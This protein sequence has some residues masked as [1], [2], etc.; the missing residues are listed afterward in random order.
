MTKKTIEEVESNGMTYEPTCEHGVHFGGCNCVVCHPEKL[1]SMAWLFSP[2]MDTAYAAAK[3]GPTPGAAE[4]AA[5]SQS[6]DAAQNAN[7][8]T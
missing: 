2:E 8:L 1:A 4:L 3:G 5:P 6:S 7:P